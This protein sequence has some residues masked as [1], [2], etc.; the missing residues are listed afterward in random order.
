MAE[1]RA[2][3]AELVSKTGCKPR[4]PLLVHEEIEYETGKAGLLKLLNEVATKA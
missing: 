4:D 3:K 1:V 2:A